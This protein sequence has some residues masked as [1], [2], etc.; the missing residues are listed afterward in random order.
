MVDLSK[1]IPDPVKRRVCSCGAAIPPFK[2]VTKPHVNYA[3]EPLEVV[4]RGC[5][6]CKL[7]APTDEP[8][9]PPPL[10]PQLA[11][12]QEEVGRRTA[13]TT[14][15]ENIREHVAYGHMPEAE[16]LANGLRRY[17]DAEIKKALEPK[18]KAVPL[19]VVKSKMGAWDFETGGERY[20][21]HIVRASPGPDHVVVPKDVFD[22]TPL[23]ST[24]ILRDA[25]LEEAM[26]VAFPAKE[27]EGS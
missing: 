11:E 12:A 14:S 10:E 7:E 4:P 5:D 27:K 26:A 13:F 25:S 20:L 16:F 22:R 23:G 3:T 24:V 6:R 18:P 21:L 19:G 17:V 1:L 8:Y 2:P 9:E 15:L